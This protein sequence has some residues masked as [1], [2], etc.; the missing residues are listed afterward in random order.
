MIL[1][2][3]SVLHQQCS[4]CPARC[5]TKSGC[6]DFYFD[7]GISISKESSFTRTSVRYIS[8]KVEISNNTS[9]LAFSDIELKH[10]QRWASNSKKQKSSVAFTI[11]SRSRPYRSSCYTWAKS[12]KD[13]LSTLL[14][15]ESCY[16]TIYFHKSLAHPARTIL[17]PKLIPRVAEIGGFLF[18]MNYV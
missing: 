13:S 12:F 10:I 9:D 16:H 4:L 14:D 7:V 8:S 2:L 15:T 17:C 11:C 5:S 18:H 6:R 3:L 1:F